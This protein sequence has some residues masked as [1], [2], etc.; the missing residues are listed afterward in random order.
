LLA[1]PGLA[2]APDKNTNQHHYGGSLIQLAGILDLR[3]SPALIQIEHPATTVSPAKPLPPPHFIATRII[4][5]TA[6]ETR[7]AMLSDAQEGRRENAR[8]A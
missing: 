5:A 6:A 7:R 2:K 1:S 3:S 8:R 4:F